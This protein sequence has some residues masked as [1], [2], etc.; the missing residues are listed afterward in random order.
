[1]KTKVLTCMVAVLVLATVACKK[2]DPLDLKTYESVRLEI[3]KSLEERTSDR[4]ALRIV[5][6]TL[7]SKNIP[8]KAFDLAHKQHLR[9]GL[10][11][12]EE[13]KEYLKLKRKYSDQGDLSTNELLAGIAYDLG[14]SGQGILIEILP[15]GNL[16]IDC[17]IM[18]DVNT[19]EPFMADFYRRYD[20]YIPAVVMAS[21]EDPSQKVLDVIQILERCGAQYIYFTDRFADR[22]LTS[23]TGVNTAPQGCDPQ[24]DQKRHY[25]VEDGKPVELS[26]SVAIYIKKS[27]Q[28]EFNAQ[29]V[30]KQNLPMLVKRK[31]DESRLC[32]IKIDG[33]VVWEDA[34]EIARACRKSG[35]RRIVLLRGEPL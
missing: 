35:C 15:E 16:R 1:M 11:Y 26:P 30:E 25:I 19:F 12:T 5:K 31:L 17:R 32:M 22:I 3:Q 14:L 13:F 33:A 20:P 6:R 4:H 28:Y 10:T 9:M 18:K 34:M 24:A 23:S 7:S 2:P 21:P 27:G 29:E 8:Y